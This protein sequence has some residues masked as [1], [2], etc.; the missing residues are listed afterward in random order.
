V[1]VPDEVAVELESRLAEAEEETVVEE[2]EMIE[3]E[4]IVEE[5]EVVVEEEV[6]EETTAPAEP[7]RG[8]W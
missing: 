4:V 3:E 5:E 6:M 8:L 2:E 1:L 7:V